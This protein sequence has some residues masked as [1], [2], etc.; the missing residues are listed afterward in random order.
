MTTTAPTERAQP[1]K[2][3]ALNAYRDVERGLVK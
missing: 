1:V 3:A 2:I